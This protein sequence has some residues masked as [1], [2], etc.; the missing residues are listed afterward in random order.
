M[1]SPTASASRIPV[2]VTLKYLYAN[3]QTNGPAALGLNIRK[4]MTSNYGGYTSTAAPISFTISVSDPVGS[5]PVAASGSCTAAANGLTG[6]CTATFSAAPGSAS[7]SGTLTE[8]GQTIATFSKISIIQPNAAN[9]INFTANPVV[10]SVSLQ[11][12]AASVNAGTPSD[13]LLTLNAF[14]A[15]GD[16]IAGNAPYV[17]SA[18][19][20]VAFTF[21]TQNAQAGG[22]GSVVVTGPPRV[23]SPA[24]AANYA[25]YD[26]RWLDH[27]NISVN[28]TSVLV[29]SLAGTALATNPASVEYAV[30][31]NPNFI[32]KGP[33]GNVYASECLN[34]SGQHMKIAKI[35]PNGTVTEF[36]T[37]LTTDCLSGITSGPDGNIWFN[38]INGNAV[39]RMTLGGVFTQYPIPTGGGPDQITSGPDGN[40]WVANCGYTN[41][42]A[43]IYRVTPSGGLTRFTSGLNAGGGVNAITLGPDGNLWFD[44]TYSNQVGRM[45]PA[46][47]AKVYTAF[48]STGGF[49]DGALTGPDGNIWYALCND[50]TIG[51]VSPSGVVIGEY[52]TGSGCTQ[53][54]AVGPDGNIWGTMYYSDALARVTMSGAVSTYPIVGDPAGITLGGDGNLWYADQDSANVGRFVF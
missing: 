52:S 6:T 28:S 27:T 42:C 44:Q 25:H 32:T 3:S 17:D 22:N 11:L 20:P 12:A 19:N 1:P 23:T 51:R 10:N 41:A 30:S 18:G 50:S 40:L 15:N 21:S 7:F 4:L 35:T 47:K 14:D 48:G 38:D 16:V 39:F 9:A 45:T 24:Q 54:I 33:D 34:G 31:Y 36:S 2:P 8:S 5:A 29:T 46:G 37:N 13:T 53:S 49:S 43:E 26:G